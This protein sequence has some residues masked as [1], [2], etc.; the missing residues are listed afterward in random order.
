MKLEPIPNRKHVGFEAIG[1]GCAQAETPFTKGSQLTEMP[2]VPDLRIEKEPF[3]KRG[4]GFREKNPLHKAR[5]AA[6]FLFFFHTG[7]EVLAGRHD[8]R[9]SS[10]RIVSGK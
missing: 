1:L 4:E 8:R 7:F 3:Q 10:Y 9:I 6:C 5:F 2:R